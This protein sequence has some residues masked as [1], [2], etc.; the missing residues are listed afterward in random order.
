M[1]FL[2]E[3]DIDYDR[4]GGRLPELRAAEHAHVRQ[5]IADGVVVVE[6]LKADRRGIVAVW[7][8]PSR[9]QLDAAIAQ[10]PMAPFLSRVEVTPLAEHPLFPGGRPPLPRASGT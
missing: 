7:D 9:A 1:L 3:V 6:W 5:L 10:V 4:I 2:L 8:C